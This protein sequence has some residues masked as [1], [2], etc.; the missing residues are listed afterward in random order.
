M[1][2]ESICTVGAI[3]NREDQGGKNTSGEAEMLRP[4]MP[5]NHFL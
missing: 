3:S 1:S 2:I 5:G 4:D